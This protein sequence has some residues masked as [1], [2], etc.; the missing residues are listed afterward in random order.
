MS[1]PEPPPRTVLGWAAG[2]EHEATAVAVPLGAPA[3]GLA[4][5]EQRYE[6]GEHL[7][8]GG[9][10]DVHRVFDRQLRRHMV[11]KI[12]ARE[13][14]R[15][16]VSLGR[17][18]QEA[19]V[20]A[21][22][23][24]PSIVPV[25]EIGIL[26]DGRP[27]YT[28]TEVRGRTLGAVI[29]AV[30]RASADGWG[31]EPGG[32]GFRRLIDVF[33]R[34]CEA[35]SYAH[36][37]GVVHRDLKPSNIMLGAFGEVLVLDWGLARIAGVSAGAAVAPST[38]RGKDGSDV[39]QAGAVA[40]TAGY[41]SPEQR[42]GDPELGAPTD[43]YALGVIL[44]EILTGAAPGLPER[45]GIPTP[46]S[47]PPWRPVPDELVAI[48]T[49]A[50]APAIAERY[51]DA[52]ALAR[53]V[54][55]FLDG[56]RKRERARELLD[57]AR[58]VM[59]RIDALRAQAAELERQ[60]RAVLEPLPPSADS[61]RKEPGWELE[62]RARE[63]GALA[64]LA[65]LEMT[66][67][68]DSSLVEADLPEAHAMLARHFRSLHE[69]A[70]AAGDPA[71]Q[72]PA[73]RLE[74][75]LR[76]HDRGEH[77]AYLAGL[78]ALTLHTEPPAEIELRRYE[79]RGRRLVDEHVRSLGIAPIRDLEL[80]RGSYLLVLRAPGCHE[81]RYPVAIGRQEHWDPRRPGDAGPTPVVLPPL[82][83]ID[84]DERFVPGGPFLCGGD[85]Q[86]AGEVMRRQRVWVDSFV[87]R[88]HPVTNRELLEMVNALID[89]RDP[90]LEELA[91]AVVPRHRGTSTGEAGTPVWPRDAGG[92]FVLAGDDEGFTWEPELPAFMISWPGA[93]AYAEWLA[94]RTGRGYRLQGELEYEKAA[95]GADGRA[96]PW[97]DFFDPT[98][99]AMRLSRELLRPVAVDEFPVDESPYGVRG[100]AGNV[101]EWCADEYRREGPPLADGLYAPP[102]G[103][104][105]DA[106]PCDRTVRGGCFFFDSFLLRAATRHNTSSVARDLS[107][108]FRL[109]RSYP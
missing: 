54:A 23:Q 32:F 27:Y 64:E 38:S 41:M 76:E 1:E 71:A 75:L 69:A 7:A 86:A 36:S 83:S 63:L 53:E 13:Y 80:P 34:V 5:P 19:Q 37:R 58:A 8:S 85:P 44:R 99:A 68:V 46:I 84:D 65:T 96:F 31:V 33:H 88:R 100:L 3:P 78:G 101:A 49:R 2:S 28:M 4:L 82:G 94:R 29:E 109:A 103:L 108:G 105:A 30:H 40:G 81:V 48:A 102:R 89:E 73:R 57:D 56:A 107:L 42:G 52:A 97:G 43:V 62:D 45:L 9:Q 15:D 87:I 90:R 16:P 77:T 93:M 21:Q 39:S 66:R 98:W 6:L 24:H 20:T 106:P 59:P 35:V 12:L 72:G 70:E 10:G 92:H 26:A 74:A 14:A 55:A 51:P 67:L 11:M 95:R 50:A 61:A 47:I 25:H 91:L 18:V 104:T 17:F 22:L 79:L 60:A